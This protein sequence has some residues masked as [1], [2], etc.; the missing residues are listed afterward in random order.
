MVLRFG[1]SCGVAGALGLAACGPGP[2]REDG[3]AS[4]FAGRVCDRLAECGCITT[5]DQQECRSDFQGFDEDSEAPTL[6]YDPACA[7]RLSQLVDTLSCDGQTSTSYIDICPLYH[8]VR[9]EG[10]ACGPVD[11]A[12][13]VESR[14]CGRELFCIAQVCRDPAKTSF[15]GPNE[16]CDILACDPGLTCIEQTCQ[17]LPGPGQPCPEG[18]CQSGSRCVNEPAD[19]QMKCE[20]LATVG[21]ACMGHSECTSGNC[22]RGQCE[23]PASIGDDCGPTLPCDPKYVCAEGACAWPS[24]NLNNAGSCEPLMGSLGAVLGM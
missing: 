12:D 2:G 10:E 17:R 16:P 14:A 24:D 9:R 23:L 20:A 7:Q 15:G 3:L 22:P 19:D 4:G 5:E 18:D 21:Q 11:P 8:G 1:L 13:G 6:A